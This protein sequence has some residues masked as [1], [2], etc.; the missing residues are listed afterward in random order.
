MVRL[1]I[2]VVLLIL[3]GIFYKTYK[4]SVFGKKDLNTNQHDGLVDEP[5]VQAKNMDATLPWDL[6][7]NTCAINPRT[8]QLKEKNGHHP[9]LEIFAVAQPETVGTVQLNKGIALLELGNNIKKT[10]ITLQ[11][12]TDQDGD[13]GGIPAQI[14]F[15]HATPKSEI[16][17]LVGKRSLF[18]AFL[19][20]KKVE[21]QM[22]TGDLNKI[23]RFV[24]P[25]NENKTMNYIGVYDYQTDSLEVGCFDTGNQISLWKTVDKNLVFSVRDELLFG[26]NEKGHLFAYNHELKPVEHPFINTF[27]EIFESPLES[28]VGL[29]IHPT[30][31]IAFVI[32][33]QNNE[34]TLWLLSWQDQEHPWGT[35]MLTAKEI[36]DLQVSTDLQW[37]RFQSYTSVTKLYVVR[38]KT[39]S[40]DDVL[41]KENAHLLVQNPI[42]LEHDGTEIHSFAW[43][44][45]PSG[46]VAS[47]REGSLH[48]WIFPK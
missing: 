36:F 41:T 22:I 48:K 29:E 35:P 19:E 7:K 1:L 4:D 21:K 11:P 44:S 28:Y 33:E 14:Y 26:L 10:K 43:I 3:L 6:G 13:A 25:T 47:T 17:N 34:Q 37:M 32:T 46:L 42:Q 20:E 45:D 18:T 27:R 24:H 8:Y 15:P 16:I 39:D 2:A 31:P 38:I 9:P 30:L 40:M 12:L 5:C 23:I